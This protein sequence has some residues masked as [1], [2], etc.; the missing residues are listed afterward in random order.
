MQTLDLLRELLKPR[1]ALATFWWVN[2][3]LIVAFALHQTLARGHSSS[4]V[5]LA[6][7]LGFTQ[8]WIMVSEARRFLRSLRAS[9]SVKSAVAAPGSRPLSPYSA[10]SPFGPALRFYSTRSV[11]AAVFLPILL[12]GLAIRIL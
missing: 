3:G 9:H 6:M 8:I 1:Y 2:E 12:L 5:A 11:V 7:L 4:I 10:L